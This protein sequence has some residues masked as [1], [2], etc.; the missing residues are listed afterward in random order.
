M[1]DHLVKIVSK[2]GSL[3][4]FACITTGLCQD[5]CSRLNTHPLATAALS[6]ALTCGVLMGS[7]MAP[8]Q[9][10]ALKFE[11]NGP[12]RKIVVEADGACRVCG[13]V[14]EPGV[15]TLVKNDRLDVAAGL[16]NVGFL[17]VVKDIGLKQPY[18]G[19]VHLVSS[20]IGEDVAF[21]LTSSEQIPS[22]VGVGVFI[23][24]NGQVAGSAG[25]LIQAMPPSQ[26]ANIESII[27]RINS[28]DSLSTI[29]REGRDAVDIL[30]HLFSEVPFKVVE[31]Q[32]VQFYCPCSKARF[33]KGL[34][35]LG[36]DELEKLAAEKEITETICEFC[37]TPYEFTREEVRAIAASVEKKDV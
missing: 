21:Y 9:R 18:S 5:I 16:G 34:K 7:T 20:Q 17:T 4:G 10:V 22:S 32:R 12:L 27:T 28:L 29:A 6:R 8:D 15:E 36:K 33:E 35:S 3:R 2:S 1:N 31:R 19:M 24:E 11:G 37:R 13:Y 23:E 25:F 26:D 14:A 30:Q